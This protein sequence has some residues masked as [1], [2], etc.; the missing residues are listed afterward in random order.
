[1]RI[2]GTIDRGRPARTPNTSGSTPARAGFNL[3]DEQD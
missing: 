1:M 2:V 3:D